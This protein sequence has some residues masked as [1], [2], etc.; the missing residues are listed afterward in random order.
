M[1]PVG[2]IGGGGSIEQIIALRQ[3]IID[4]SK[5]LQEVHQPKPAAPTETT[6]TTPSFGDTLRTA[7]D[8]VNAVQAESGRMTAAYERGEETDIAKV[9]LARQESSV[10][11][12]ATLQVRNKLLAAYQ[13]TMRMGI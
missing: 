1:N 13:E 4:R 3:Q 7:L 2:G 8:N 9:M 10:A 6:A 11:F 5:V 12:E